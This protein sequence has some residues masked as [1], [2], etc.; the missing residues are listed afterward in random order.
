MSVGKRRVLDLAQRLTKPRNFRII[1]ISIYLDTKFTQNCLHFILVSSRERV[2]FSLFMAVSTKITVAKSLPDFVHTFLQ[3]Y[4]RRHLEI[5]S[6]RGV[7]KY[8]LIS[9]YE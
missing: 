3:S 6:R 2:P 9:K 5:I 8:M 7:N 4:G 1:F